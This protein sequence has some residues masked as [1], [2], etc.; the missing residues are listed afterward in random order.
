VPPEIGV[1]KWLLIKLTQRQRER[2]KVDPSPLL[3]GAARRSEDDGNESSGCG[4]SACGACTVHLAGVAARSCIVPISHVGDRP[5]VTIEGIGQDA[6]DEWS[7]RRGL[8]RTWSSA[9]TARAGRSWRRSLCSR[10]VPKPTDKNIDESMGGNICRCATYPAYSRSDQERR[11][12]TPG[13][14]R[15]MAASITLPS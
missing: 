12:S 5:I 14:R 7:R 2:S 1:R 15:M 3:W 10:H 11:G 4:I 9:A 8:I 6:V 13:R